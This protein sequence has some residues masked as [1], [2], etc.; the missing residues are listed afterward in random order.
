MMFVQKYICIKKW[1]VNVI[2]HNRFI[3]FAFCMCGGVLC[4][5][6]TQM[7]GLD[8]KRC[9]AKKKF[10]FKHMKWDVIIIRFDCCYIATLAFVDCFIWRVCCQKFRWMNKKIVFWCRKIL[11]FLLYHYYYSIFGGF[12]SFQ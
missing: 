2:S 3:S 4:L 5:F 11:F 10:T 8:K 12:V 9:L 1:Q 6:I 7:F